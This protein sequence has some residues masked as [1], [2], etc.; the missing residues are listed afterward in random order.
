MNRPSLIVIA[1]CIA[2]FAPAAVYSQAADSSAAAAID[3]GS[4]PAPRMGPWGFDTA[5]MDRSVRP[6]Q[7]FSGFASGAW[8]RGNEIPADRASWGSFHALGELSETRTRRLVEGYSLGNPDRD[9]DRAK[10]AAL[11]RSF[12]DEA[13]VEAAGARP[14][15]PLVA[16]IRAVD[17][18]D[19]LAETMAQAL[20]GFGNSF[21]TAQ[22]FDD[23]RAPET[24]ALY[25]FQ[26]GLGLSD[27]DFYLDQRFAAQKTRYQQYVE[28]MLGLIG[29]ERPAEAAAAIVAM[30][31]TI[32][33][34]H[35][36]RADSRD[37][38]KTYNAVTLA[39][40]ESQAP[41]F[42]WRRFF[43]AAGMD[44]AERAVAW[45][46]TAFPGIARVFAET[47]LDVLKAW[48][49]FHVADNA[50][51]YLSR[52]FV[53]ARFEFRNRFLNGQPQNRDRW[54][55][56]LTFAETGMGDAIGQDYVRL[57]FPPE[58][59]AQMSAL[60]DNL[61]TAMRHRLENLTW[62]S[63]ET[64]AQ[65]LAKLA[66]FEVRIGMPEV[67][68][69]YSQLRVANDDLF[70]NAS[71]VAAF[72]W[73]DQRRRI[74]Q[75]VDRREWG[76]TPQTVN[77]S[78]SPPRNAI[79]FPAAILQPPFF[80][81]QADPAVNYGAIGG[82]IGHE[83]IH[84]F[85]DQGR[86]SDGAGILRDWWQPQDAA[87]FE[88]QAA[89]LGAQYEAVT[90]PNL[91]DMRLNGRVTMGENIGDLGGLTIAYE[92]YR[93]SL[94]GNEAPVIDGF[95]GDQRFFLGWA[96]VWR[97]LWRDDS[98]R[99][100]IVNGPHSPGHVRAFGPIRNMDAWYAAFD[101]QPGDP[102]YIPPEQ[103][104]RIW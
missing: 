86:K 85:D 55:R 103:R 78:Y 100:Q 91:P 90:F 70:G 88:A 26:G 104:V 25:L 20:G 44:Q 82:V 12:L 72:N 89:R 21:F 80:D 31:T 102:L 98:L 40:L 67:W 51:P 3:S 73:D 57:Y 75:R 74:G 62:M 17:S 29:W 10:V 36:N 18:K 30:E 27:R 92:A 83:I 37:R 68:Q 95:T 14:L 15:Q 65:A 50:A 87:A 59:R 77:A 8:L 71:R 46:N 79:T 99:Q 45:Q 35:W 76:M 81:P 61:K 24:N 54:K 1:T 63:A 19:A 16:R 7:D 47:D 5:G 23:M 4:I 93:A 9:G 28:Q 97:T 6:G 66:T 60:V 42:P 94:N 13:A 53:D 49:A 43:A 41:G 96:Q 56:A 52:Q 38:S 64:K 48:Q 34:S 39:D 33:Q 69:D 58:S 101:I 32:A 84:G 11:Y 2:A 22:V